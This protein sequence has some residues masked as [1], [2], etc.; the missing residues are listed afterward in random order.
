MGRYLSRHFQETFKPT[1]NGKIVG[2]AFLPQRHHP[3]LR[4]NSLLPLRQLI[5]T[6]FN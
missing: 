4:F 2:H 3:A 6:T 5:G 1:Q